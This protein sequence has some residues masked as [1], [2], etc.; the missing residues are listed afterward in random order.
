VTIEIKTAMKSSSILGLKKIFY[1]IYIILVLQNDYMGYTH[2]YSR[3][4]YFNPFPNLVYDFDTF[5]ILDVNQSAINHYGY[6]SEEFLS[7]KITDLSIKEERLKVKKAHLNICNEGENIC[8]GTFTHQ[9]KNGENI[10]MDT[11]GH[12]IDF[13]GRKCIMVI[14]QD[15]TIK[16]GQLLELQESN[17]KLKEAFEEKIKI[18]ESIGDAFFTMDSNFIVTYWNKTAEELI[19]LKRDALLG[20]NLWDVFPDAVS[21]PSYTNYHKV[22]ET[23]EPIMF[24]DYYGGW[25]EVNAYPS[26]DGI[27]VFFRDISH[28]KEADDRLLKAY[29]EKNQILESIGDA[30]F[31]VDKDWTIT[32]WNKEAENVLGKKKD[33]ILG[34]NLWEEY[35]DAIDTDFYRQYH[36]AVATGKTVSFEEHYPTLNKWFEVSAY[37]SSKGLSVYFRDITLRKETDIRII[38]ANER[39]EK[40]TQAATDAIW[41]WDIENDTFYR[42]VGFDKLFGYEVSKKL[43][44][45]EFWEERFHPKDL[46]ELKASLNECL[47][48][49]SKEY[50]QHEYRIL[51]KD[52]EEKTVI[53]KGVIIRNDKGKGIRMVGAI[54]DISERI[55]YEDSLCEL[56]KILK[57]NIKEL[58]ISNEQLEQFAFIASHDLQEPLRMISSFLN[59]I[60]R[61]YGHQLDDKAQQYIHFATDGAKRMKQIILDLLEYSRAG[62]LSDPIESVNLNELINDYRALRRRLIKEKKASIIV[63]ALPDVKCFKV[64]LIQTLHCLLDNAIKY[65]KETEPPIIRISALETESYWQVTIEDNGI[66]IDSQFFDK[67]FI[68]FQRLHNRDKYGGTGIGLSI[69]KKH[70]ESWGGKIWVE[71]ESGNG[72]KF[73]FTIDKNIEV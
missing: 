31:A 28:R 34:K 6:S 63:D 73:C 10:R 50:W 32:Y 4:F 65:V 47:Q 56:N 11:N 27:S 51:Q 15:V 66:G 48:N 49:P 67:I 57:K 12:K 60:E 29:D 43:K 14:C 18:I 17:K 41:D 62:K 61:K 13:Q 59:Q 23:G 42:G 20:K 3:L 69:A 22:M 37:P 64:P 46:P 72:S 71:S 26:N 33:T 68:I 55:K 36:K 45:T 21:L 58:Q 24:E 54:T 30:F 40:V 53:D 1:Y 19:G 7:I 35:A 70:V 5:E 38:Q 44:G 25:L 8:F 16:E 9:K 2:D 39:F 52:G